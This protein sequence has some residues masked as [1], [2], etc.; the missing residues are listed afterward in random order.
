MTDRHYALFANN[1][2]PLQLS[3][4][5]EYNKFLRNLHNKDYRDSQIAQGDRLA[6]ALEERAALLN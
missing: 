5:E 6:Q 2:H 1:S 4:Y 3:L